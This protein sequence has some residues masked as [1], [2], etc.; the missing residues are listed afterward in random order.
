MNKGRFDKLPPEVQ[1]FS[2]RWATSTPHVFAAAQG[3]PPRPAEKME[4][5]GARSANCPAAERKRWAD[6][7]RPWPKPGPP[8]CRA[9]GVPGEQ[10]LK[11]YVEG[12]KRR[13]R[14]CPRL[15]GQIKDACAHG[16]PCNAGRRPQGSG[17]RIL[18]TAAALAVSPRG[19]GPSMRWARCGSW[20]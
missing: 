13:A 12:L 10:V 2:A 15:V 14:T 5:A 7:R 6:A 17:V 11:G 19:P 20:R 3:L 8:T 4:E 16:L 18:R 1:R 9:K